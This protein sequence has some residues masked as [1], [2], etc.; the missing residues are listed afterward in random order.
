MFELYVSLKVPAHSI[1][2]AC[3]QRSKVRGVLVY[4]EIEIVELVARRQ[5]GLGLA[6]GTDRLNNRFVAILRCTYR[7]SRV[8]SVHF[9][10]V[11]KEKSMEVK[12]AS[13]STGHHGFTWYQRT[14]VPDLLAKSIL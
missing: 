3:T 7:A 4:C 9:H 12:C 8:A 14:V 6:T 2:G 11:E 13:C 10:A 1:S 5:S